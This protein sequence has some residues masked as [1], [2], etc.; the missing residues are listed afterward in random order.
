MAGTKRPR[1]RIAAA[2][3]AA[4]AARRAGQQVEASR[5]RRRI[6]QREL[7]DRVGVSRS[8]IA[9]IESGQAAG[10]PLETW[11]ALGEALD[12]PFR[13]EFLRD[14]QA[15]P[16]D[17]GH[18]GMQELVLRLAGPA[19][20]AGTF[21]LATRPGDPTRSV[22]VLLLDKRSRRMVI[23]ECWNTFGDLGAAARSSDRK[24]AEAAQLA[25]AIGG[26]GP[27]FDIGLVWVVRD[28]RVNRAL[29]ERYPHI[30][31]RRFPGPSGAWVRALTRPAAMPS[32]PGLIWC[33]GKATRLFARRR[34][35]RS[36]AAGQ[37][38]P[39]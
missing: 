14:H 5:R 37:R 6:T 11:F 31:E 9:A 15:L 22:D 38:D 33:D 1:A 28:T 35:T 32:G 8:L 29:I 23:V 19:G 36:R 27:P 7:G 3:K 34:P 13:A 18:L 24:L 12:R 26:A 4:E 30:F 17:A 10:T 2:A 21:E 25:V 39:A 20:Y 16:A